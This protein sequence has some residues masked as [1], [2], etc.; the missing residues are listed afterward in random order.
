M[1]VIVQKGKHI[2][3]IYLKTH[4][5]TIFLSK[6]RNIALN[7]KIIFGSESFTRWLFGA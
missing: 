3:G 7:K 2:A 6:K 4:D 5:V 1:E